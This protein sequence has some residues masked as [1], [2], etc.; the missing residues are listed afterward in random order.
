MQVSS[1][2]ADLRNLREELSVIDR[3]DAVVDAS[4]RSDDHLGFC[5]SIRQEAYSVCVCA[6]CFCPAA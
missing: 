1:I 3:S 2:S 4:Q 5:K 6:R